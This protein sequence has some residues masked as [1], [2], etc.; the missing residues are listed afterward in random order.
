[1]LN[2]IKNLF[3]K[4]EEEQMQF[5]HVASGCVIISKKGEILAWGKNEKEAELQQ[6]KHIKQY[7]IPADK[8]DLF[9]KTDLVIEDGTPV[10]QTP[11]EQKFEEIKKMAFDMFARAKSTNDGY[12]GDTD[13]MLRGYWHCATLFYNFAKEKDHVDNK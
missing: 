6:L 13:Q 5:A 10:L 7:V 1:M 12:L 8:I 11:Q 2:K 4:K 3:R 9:K